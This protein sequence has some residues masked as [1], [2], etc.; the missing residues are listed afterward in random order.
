MKP[1]ESTR[2]EIL[3]GF[4]WNICLQRVSWLTAIKTKACLK[5]LEFTELDVQSVF[6]QKF[7][8]LFHKDVYPILLAQFNGKEAGVLCR[9]VTVECKRHHRTSCAESRVVCD[10]LLHHRDSDSPCFPHAYVHPSSLVS[11]R[12]GPKKP[13]RGNF[14]KFA[15]AGMN[16]VQRNSV[17]YNCLGGKTSG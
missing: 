10:I 6:F 9:I 8:N 5:K 7:P 14:S 11:K 12:F 2:A 13:R 17:S 4:D 1:L 16:R 3:F 15:F